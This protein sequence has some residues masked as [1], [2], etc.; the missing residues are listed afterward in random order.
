MKNDIQRNLNWINII[1]RICLVMV[2]AIPV[3][4]FDQP[5]LIVISMYFLSTA[6]VG[7]DPVKAYMMAGK[8]AKEPT[9]RTSKHEMNSLA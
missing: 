6:L 7:W 8:T 3:M 4:V 5:Y 9:S 1:A 2:G